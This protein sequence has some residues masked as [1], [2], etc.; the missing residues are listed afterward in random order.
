MAA[1]TIKTIPIAIKMKEKN[2]DFLYPDFLKIL[3]TG[4]PKITNAEKMAVVTR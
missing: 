4:I 2:I 1:G 3:P